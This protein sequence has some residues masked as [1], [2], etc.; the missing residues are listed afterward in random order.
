MVL[1]TK[2]TSKTQYDS[3][4]QNKNKYNTLNILN[5]RK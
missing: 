1:A 4:G 3:E 2:R 5:I